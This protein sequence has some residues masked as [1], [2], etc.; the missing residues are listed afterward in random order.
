[1]P[2]KSKH[3]TSAFPTRN[4]RTTKPLFAWSRK[5]RVASPPFPARLPSRSTPLFRCLAITPTIRSSSKGAPT[6]KANSPRSA[7]RDYTWDD[8]YQYHP[9]TI[10]SE[11][12][13]RELFQDPQAAIGKRVRVGTTDD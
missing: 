11:N 13:A 1:M 4:P 12:T 3:S 5:S 9:V 7:G 10:L 6:P 2:A 8:L